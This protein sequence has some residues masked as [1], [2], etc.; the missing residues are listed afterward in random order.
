MRHVGASLSLI[1]LTAISPTSADE[2]RPQPP[3]GS[4][5]DGL[6]FKD[7]RFLPRTPSDFGP[8]AAYVFIASNTTCPVGQ[9]YWPVLNELE[10]AYRPRGVQ[11]AALNVGP[12]DTIVE[13]AAQ[14]V[15]M[16]V[17]FPFVKDA[18]GACVSALG[19]SRTPEAVVLDSDF[20]L[21]YRGRI[22]DRH[23][24][25][26]S[27]SE[28]TRDDLK[29]AIEAVLAGREVAVAET[30]VDGCRIT[31]PV[32]DSS[33]DPPTFSEAVEPILR[34]HCRPCHRPGT[35]TPFPLVTYRDAAAQGET[36]AEVVADRRMPPWFASERH[37]TFVNRRSLDDVERETIRRWVRGGMPRG[38]RVSG[39]D[40]APA[41]R[42]GGWTI[43]EP[44]VVLSV[45]FAHSI[46][47]SGDVEYR[48]AV[49]PHVFVEDTWA[50]AVE[51]LPDNPR[52]VHHANLG[53][54]KLGE[55]PSG[56][57][58]LTGRVP[59][60]EPLSLDE[61]QAV[62]I[63]RG[64]VLGLQIHY[65]TTG[66]PEK[67]RLSV[68]LRFPRSTVRK[69]LYHTQVYTT[70]FAI[71][72]HA[73]AH[74]VTA[75]RKLGFDATGV[76]LF[77]HMHL[78]GR[79]ATFLAHRP[80]GTS[81]TL[82]LIPNYNFDWQL[83]YRF[84]PG[85]VRFPAGTTFEVAAHFDNSRFNPY[86]PDPDATVGHGDQ[87]R[88]EMMYGFFFYLRDDEDLNLTVDPRTGRVSKG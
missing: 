51:I 20:R 83:P 21:R 78:R 42:P 27:R 19:L 70:G 4:R 88:D 85:R 5:V 69:R 59:G 36:I 68:G 24:L 8:K 35:E 43:G 73:P 62:L 40:Q 14:A 80:D 64:S 58:F 34:R 31:P 49:L 87:T 46:P 26:G 63:P 12:E 67:A 65:V 2:S 37:G 45:P 76:G 74:A 44:D 60:G 56:E 55:A 15:E 71:P 23:R 82:L 47:A 38:S 75:R 66:K 72:P 86:N 1:L 53:Y 25:G 52:V 28:P 16:G 9:R 81:E 39:E 79:D 57:N 6:V 33:E 54:A 18:D 48:Y 17:E 84:E 77:S 7:I 3:I 32:V 50:Q 11:F 29:E 22:D 61:G 10:R 13:M 41:E 30:P